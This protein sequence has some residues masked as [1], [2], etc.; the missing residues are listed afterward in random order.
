MNATFGGVAK[1]A[2]GQTFVFV[3]HAPF[4]HEFSAF[5]TVKHLL[6]SV[7]PAGTQTYCM[8]GKH[9]GT[10]HQRTIVSTGGDGSVGEY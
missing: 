1:D 3:G 4:L 5:F 2:D 8:S 6:T 9:E 10:H 7:N